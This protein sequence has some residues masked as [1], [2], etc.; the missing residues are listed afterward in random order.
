M[1]KRHVVGALVA[2]AALPFGVLVATAQ[3]APP[4]RNE[5][6]VISHV[7]IDKDDPS[8]GYVRARYTCQP[9]IDHLWVSVKQTADGTADSALTEEGSGFGHVAATW[10]QSHPVG[11]QC[12]GKNHVQVFEVNTAEQVPPEFGGGTVGYGQLVRGQGYVQFCLTSSSN[13]ELLIAD[14]NFQYVK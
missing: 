5:A 7:T 11:L 4:A 12:D 9:H 6:T 10:V 3:A 13:E 14:Q 2:T 1:R 8:V